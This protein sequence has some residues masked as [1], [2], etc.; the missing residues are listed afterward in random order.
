MASSHF[1]VIPQ[2]LTACPPPFLPLPAQ[3][4]WSFL[5][6]VHELLEMKTHQE[7]P[8]RKRRGGTEKPRKG[9]DPLQE[10]SHDQ[11]VPRPLNPSQKEATSSLKQEA[12]R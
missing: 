2:P 3:Y 9:G 10:Y 12:G 5:S 6:P 4:M 7:N 1:S 11:E 8:Q